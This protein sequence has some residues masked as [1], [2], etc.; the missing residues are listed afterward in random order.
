M[1]R[2]AGFLGAGLGFL[3]SALLVG[4]VPLVFSPY[5]LMKVLYGL[6]LF[7]ASDAFVGSFPDPVLLLVGRALLFPALGCFMLAALFH[8]ARRTP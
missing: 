2:A 6:G 5:Q 1:S 4:A 8:F 7:R 3:L